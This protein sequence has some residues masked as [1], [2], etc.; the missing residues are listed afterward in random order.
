[1][2]TGL[3]GESLDRGGGSERLGALGRRKVRY[4]P[5]N[6]TRNR[7][8]ERSPK[9]LT[10]AP[11]DKIESLNEWLGENELR[12]L[13]QGKAALYREPD[14]FG[15]ARLWKWDTLRSGL[16]AATELVPT[17]FKDTRRAIHLSHP[18]LSG[19]ATNT[20]AMAVQLV[21]AGESV[22][23]HRHTLAAMRFVIEGSPDVCYHHRWRE[24]QHGAGR[25]A[26][27]AKLGLA[28]PHQR[29]AGARDVDRLL[30]HGLDVDAAHGVLRVPLGGEVP[31]AALADGQRDTDPGCAGASGSEPAEAVLQVER[32]PASAA[33]HVAGAQEPL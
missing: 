28:Q 18:S 31:D 32:D 29:L 13:W 14:P 8:V 25:P 20:L 26:G 16:E 23:A 22:F 1:M 27:A 15:P 2:L 19:G 24:V 3:S 11:M 12:G 17:D 9:V 6:T 7:A 21:K 10:K 4:N 30:G 5:P 33:G